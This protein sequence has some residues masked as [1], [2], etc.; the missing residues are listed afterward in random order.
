[1]LGVPAGGA[2]AANGAP[3]RMSDGTTAGMI[4]GRDLMAEMDRKRQV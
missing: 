4:S 3:K 1:M 2:A